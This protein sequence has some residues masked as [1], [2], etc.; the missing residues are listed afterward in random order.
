MESLICFG[1]EV[2]SGLVEGEGVVRGRGRMFLGRFSVGIVEDG[3]EVEL[4]EEE[5]SGVFDCLRRVVVRGNQ[6]DFSR[7]EKLAIHVKREKS[8]P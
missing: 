8:T 3:I 2:G 4:V 7:P 1:E 6:G 5:G